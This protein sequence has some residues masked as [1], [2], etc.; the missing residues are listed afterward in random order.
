MMTV[1]MIIFAPQKSENVW[2]MRNTNRIWTSHPGVVT[3]QRETKQNS[4]FYGSKSNTVW[5]EILFY[6]S[7]QILNSCPP[8][9]NTQTT[10]HCYCREWFDESLPSNPIP[11]YNCTELENVLL[12]SEIKSTVASVLWERQFWMETN[13]GVRLAGSKVSYKYKYKYKYY[14]VFH[15]TGPPPKSSKYG[16]PQ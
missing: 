1:M 8:F 9:Q 2:M 10:P 11:S 12:N 15:L 4:D 6:P 16:P 5:G 13:M 7:L 3:N 14:R